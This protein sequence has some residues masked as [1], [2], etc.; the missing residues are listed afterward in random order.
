M[1]ATNSAPNKFLY[2]KSTKIT[3]AFDYIDWNDLCDLVKNPVE[4]EGRTIEEAK[5]ALPV[6]AANDAPDKQKATVLQHD[7]FT[8]LRLD[9]DDTELGINGVT[10]KLKGLELESFI[11]HTSSSHLA[12]GKGNRYRVFIE[13]ASSVTYEAWSTVETYLSLLFSADDCAA[14]PQQIMYAPLDTESYDYRI[15]KGKAFEVEGSNL[16]EEAKKLKQQQDEQ[17]TKAED[18]PVKPQY[19]PKLV[20]KQISIIDLVNGGYDWPDLLSSFGYKR[21]GKAWLPPEAT[22]KQ[23]GAY[24]LRSHTDGKE[25]YFSHHENDPCA[26]GRSIDK[27]DFIALRVYGGSQFEALK[28]IAKDYFPDVHKH[29][30]QEYF[31]AKHNDEVNAFRAL[32]TE[33]V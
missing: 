4:L 2:A 13:I 8:M 32:F 16:L 9:L 17:I 29:N 3:K 14:R 28:G 24:I 30:Q 5:K 6:I 33:A 12:K 31:T 23:A 21:Q 18:K 1:K 10:D 15:T 25:R 19:E 7:N 27:F 20:G 22:S 11:I 26:T